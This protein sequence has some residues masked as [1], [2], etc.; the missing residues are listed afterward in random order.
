[1]EEFEGGFLRNMMF[2]FALAI[3]FSIGYVYFSN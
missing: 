3:L 1:M 2:G